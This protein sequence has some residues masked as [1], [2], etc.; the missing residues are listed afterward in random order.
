MTS[1]MIPPTPANLR[2]IAFKAFWTGAA[3]VLSTLAVDLADVE[4]WW[5][6]M[7]ATVVNYAL[8]WV[9]ERLGSTT[10]D[11][12]PAGVLGQLDAR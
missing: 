1:T 5:I 8:A 2:N 10:P 4:A 12:P 11:L 7:V 6:P 9:R 3:V